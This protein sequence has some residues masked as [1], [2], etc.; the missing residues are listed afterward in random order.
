MYKIISGVVI[1]VKIYNGH[2]V[3]DDY[4]KQLITVSCPDVD[5][6]LEFGYHTRQWGG[7]FLAEGDKV[8]LIVDETNLNIYDVR[9][10]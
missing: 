6:E 9:R 2:I 1:D 5:K 7:H 4:I 3:K 8:K 10:D